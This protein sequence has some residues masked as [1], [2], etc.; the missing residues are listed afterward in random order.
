MPMI[1]D[2]LQCGMSAV[3]RIPAVKA[4]IEALGFQVGRSRDEFERTIAIDRSSYTKVVASL[5]LT[6]D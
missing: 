3:G 6:L 2:G 5:G 4:D 1:E